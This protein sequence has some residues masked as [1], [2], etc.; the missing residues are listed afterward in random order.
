MIKLEADPGRTWPG[1]AGVEGRLGKSE[2]RKSL[3]S[4][5]CCPVG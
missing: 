1:V 5:V 3:L 2:K 4:G